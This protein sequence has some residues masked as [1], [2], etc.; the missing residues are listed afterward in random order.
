MCVHNLKFQ[1]KG[2]I[3]SEKVDDYVLDNCVHNVV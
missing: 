2:G 3:F 1:L